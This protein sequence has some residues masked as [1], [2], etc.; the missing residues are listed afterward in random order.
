MI[1]RIKSDNFNGETVNITF[2]P[3]TGGTIN[4]TGVVIPYDYVSDYPYG[5]YSIFIPSANKSCPL[6]VP[7][8]VATPT[9]TITPTSTVTPTPTIT[10]SSTPTPTPTPSPSLFDAN[11]SISPTGAT[12]YENV[13]LTG[14]TNISSP[15]YIWSLTGF[16]DTS[17]N[18]ISSYTGNPLTE[19]YFTSTGSSNV[20]LSVTG[21][22]GS[23]T[24]TSFEVIGWTPADISPDVWIDPSDSSTVTLRT[25]GGTDYVES[26][27][28]KGDTSVMT[29]FTQSNRI[30]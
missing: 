13:I 23:G 9:P 4:I 21:T 20:L 29:G 7:N 8:P 26:I 18:T 17:G 10:S 24:S 12:Q 28:N 22:E 16:T 3:D 19:G 1:T 6:N 5:D 15:T 2:T 14:S 25:T 11:V 30:L 27:D